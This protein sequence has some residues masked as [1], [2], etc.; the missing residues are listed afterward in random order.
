MKISTYA[1]EVYVFSIYKCLMLNVVILRE[2][3]NR[4]FIRF[5]VACVVYIKLFFY[6]LILL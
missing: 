3:T 5:K 4:Y 6:G 1:Q 2:I